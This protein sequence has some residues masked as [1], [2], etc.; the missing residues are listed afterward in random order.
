[1]AHRFYL[2]APLIA[3]ALVLDLILGD[4]PW[5]PHPVR[6]I[7]WL[8]N[9]GER[10]L[11][12]GRPRA[13]LRS[14]TI[15]A[16]AVVLIALLSAWAI[17]AAGD[18]ISAT[19]G[20]AL[21]VAIAWTTLA[22]KGLSDAATEVERA[23]AAE[24]D[25][26]ARQAMPALVGRDPASLDHTGM[27]RATVESIA[28]NS[29]DGVIAPLLFLFIGG[30]ALA[31]AYK[32]INTLDSMIGYRS[33]RHLYFGRAAARIDDAANFIPARLTALCLIAS[34][35]VFTG[36]GVEAYDAC[37][38]GARLHP[39]LNAGYP[40][41]AMAGALGVQLGGEAV[42][43]GEV[44]NRPLLGVAGRP[45]QIEDIATARMLLRYATGAAFCT[46][47]LARFIIVRLVAG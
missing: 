35:A 47:A 22:L 44:E 26:A 29:S 4:P 28:E 41:A 30:P 31:I 37:R 1:V 3:A 46:L 20:A 15:L 25:D 12:T 27:V 45:P 9:R 43:G 39:S 23:L 16:A 11:Y 13:D 6:L 8:I 38:A 33:E 17:I 42:Y 21:A 14:G 5:M 34:A 2:S 7:G 40:E 10:A 18:A 36:R 19:L 24:N 32:A